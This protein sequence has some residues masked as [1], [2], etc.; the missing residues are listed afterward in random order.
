MAIVLCS[1]LQVYITSMLL[2][3]T[4]KIEHN[5]F[6]SRG[7]I[8]FN[9]LNSFCLLVSYLN[10]FGHI[11]LNT[12]FKWLYIIPLEIGDF[13]NFSVHVFESLTNPFPVQFSMKS[14]ICKNSRKLNEALVV[15]CQIKTLGI[16]II[17]VFS[18]NT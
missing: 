8:N 1:R 3:I 9:K 18:R 4:E 11:Q 16:P 6:L 10:T 17:P 2:F 14:H 5:F 7:S 12:L 13:N 15:E